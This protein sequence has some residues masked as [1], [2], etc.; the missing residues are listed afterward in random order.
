MTTYNPY[1]RYNQ[2]R[3]DTADQGA[4]ILASYDA[5]IRFCRAA[6]ECIAKGDKVARG[7]WLAR[8]FDIVGE[9]RSSLRPDAGG[10]VAAALGEA[11]AYIE[12]QIT[13]ANVGNTSEPL[14]MAIKLLE[15]LRETWREVV[16]QNRQQATPAAAL[17]S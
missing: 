8:A 6:A 17:V 13:L 16:R 2:V 1:Q 14:D 15:D 4:L 10:E 11:Y 3:Y 5:A 12:R 7:K 9:L